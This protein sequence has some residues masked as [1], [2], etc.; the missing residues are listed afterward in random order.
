MLSEEALHHV[1]WST[2]HSFSRADMMAEKFSNDQLVCQ[3]NK[4][5][6]THWMTEVM[7][8]ETGI[9]YTCVVIPLKSAISS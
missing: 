4:L 9:L 1:S 8:V 2:S 7:V 6:I 3:H 5:G